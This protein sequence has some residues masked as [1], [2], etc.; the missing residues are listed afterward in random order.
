MPK[1][2]SVKN[3]KNKHPLKEEHHPVLKQPLTFG[4]RAADLVAR[5][6]GSWAFIIIFMIFLVIWMAINTYLLLA[7]PFDPYP[8]ILLN[9]VLSCLSA[10][11]APVI[12]MS[13]NRQAQ[14]DRIDAKYDH[15]INRKAERENL[16]ILKDLDYIKRKLRSTK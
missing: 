3:G 5:F 8:F 13:Q 11:Q 15:A 4:Q 16:E 1:K 6:G 12:L 14:R 2:K 10:L 9:L 7:R